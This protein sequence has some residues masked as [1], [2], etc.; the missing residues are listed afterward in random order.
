M[1]MKE[2]WSAKIQSTARVGSSK[3]IKVIN[4]SI[5]PMS[6]VKKNCVREMTAPGYPVHRHMELG[7]ASDIICLQRIAGE[8]GCR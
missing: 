4:T 7:V 8:R 1:R 5:T 2:G 6:R 3:T